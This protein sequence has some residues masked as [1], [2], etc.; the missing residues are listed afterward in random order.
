MQQI[1]PQSTHLQ[2]PDHSSENPLTSNLPITFPKT[3][4]GPRPPAQIVEPTDQ[5]PANSAKS[6]DSG[7]G[8]W[9]RPQEPNTSQTPAPCNEVRPEL[10]KFQTPIN[11]ILQGC[12]RG[13]DIASKLGK[14]TLLGPPPRRPRTLGCPLLRRRGIRLSGHRPARRRWARVPLLG[15]R[16]L[17]VLQRGK[18]GKGKIFG[19]IRDRRLPCR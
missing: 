9:T 1:F 5:N 7:P 3:P 2:P 8:P 17:V 15:G 19:G 11:R 14:L 18:L 12:C 4:P 6:T 16:R 13:T 10:E